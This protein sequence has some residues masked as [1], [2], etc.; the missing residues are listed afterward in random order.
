MKYPITCCNYKINHVNSLGTKPHT[1]TVTSEI[2]QT[3]ES[4]GN[5]LINGR[6]YKMKKNSLFFIHGLSTHFVSPPDINRYNH[7]IIVLNTHETENLALHLNMTKEYSKLFTDNGGLVC[8]LSHEDVILADSVILRISKIL[9]DNEGLKYARLASALT[10]LFRIGLSSNI[11]KTQD[12]SK[13]S[14]IISYVSDNALTKITIDTICEN[15][16]ISKYH[17]CRIFKEHIGITIGDYIKNRRLSEAKQLLAD[18]E[19]SITKI[20][21]LCCFSDSSFFSKTFSKE[22]GI[23]PT[24]FRAKYR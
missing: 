10:E 2:I 21:Y 9:S 14:D 5:I 7:S 13:I 11:D 23:S 19:L 18:T 16:H 17:L 24:D 22:F 6:L 20:A 3:F 4:E 8:S 15:C 1:H 12:S